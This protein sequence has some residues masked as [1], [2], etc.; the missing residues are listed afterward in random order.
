MVPFQQGT[1]LYLS[2][3]KQTTTKYIN[4]SD[5]SLL[6]SGLIHMDVQLMQFLIN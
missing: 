2:S 1:K 4:Q 5:I 3:A 6:V